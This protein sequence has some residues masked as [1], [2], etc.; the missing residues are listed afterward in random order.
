MLKAEPL[1]CASRLD[2]VIDV[3]R[4]EGPSGPRSLLTR[5]NGR[6]ELLFPEMGILQES[7]EDRLNICLG[8]FT[9]SCLLDTQGKG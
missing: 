5:V 9:S 2:D 7:Y 6:M 8:M 4:R 1:Q 3:R